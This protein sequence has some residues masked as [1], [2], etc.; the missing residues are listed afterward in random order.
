MTSYI[1]ELYIL[2]FIPFSF[3]LPC[4][5]VNDISANIE[6]NEEIDPDFDS[7]L[8]YTYALSKTKNK[9]G[10]VFS[11]V[12]ST[13]TE[14]IIYKSELDSNVN[15]YFDKFLISENSFKEIDVQNLEENIYI[16]IKDTKSSKTYNVNF[17]IYDTEIP[18]SLIEGKPK[19]MKYFFSTNIYKFEYASSANLTFVYSSKVKLKKYLNIT[20]NDKVI[21]EK[22]I[23]ETDK[24]FYLKSD[25]LET[26][27][28]KVEI[29]D[30]EPGN[31]D[32]EFSIIVYEKGKTQFIEIGKNQ[33]IDLYHLNLNQNDEVQTFL[34]YYIL[35]STVS[36][37]IN[38]KIDSIAKTTKYINIESGLYHSTRKINSDE[39]EKIFHFGENPLP[40]EYDINSDEYKKIYFKDVDTSYYYRY[41]FF[42]IDISKLEEYYSP[43]KI[44]ITIGEEVEEIN[45]DSMNYYQT[46]TI[47]KTIKPYFPTYFKLK[48]DPKE[49]Y[50]FNSPYPKNSIYVKGDLMAYDEN[51]KII[52]NKNY[53][54]DEDEIF[55]FSDI[56]E[57]TI[58]VFCSESFRGTFYLEK[59]K[60]SDL[61][62]LENMRN[63]D[64]IEIKFEENDC[65]TK[66]KKYLLGIYNREIYSKMNKTLTK[67]WTTNNGEMNVYYR[68]N[69]TLEGQSL[70]PYLDKYTMK[71]EYYIY[72][73][74]Y[75]DFFTF[76]CVKP[77]EL[78][79]RSPYK[80]FNET[81]HSIGQNTINIIKLGTEIEILQPTTPIRPPSNYLF[82]GIFSTFGK[83]IIISPD[84]PELFNETSIEN[85]KIFTLK[86]DLYKFEPDQLAI[87]VNAN[88]LTQIEV[89]EVIRYNFT[90]Y[91]LL[92]TSEMTHFTDNH[93]VKFINKKTKKIKVTVKGLKDVEISYDL[94][95]LFTNN[96]DYLPMAY[97][98]KETVTR[99]KSA[100]NEIIELNNKYLGD[101][102]LNKKYIAFIFS[103]PSS[104]YYEFDAQVIEDIEQKNE[105]DGKKG[106][107]SILIICIIAGVIIVALV[108]FL[109][110]FCIKKK[111]E[112]DKKYEMDVENM[113]NQPL[114]N[115]NN[116][117]INDN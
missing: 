68:N 94:V 72:I 52:I 35:N 28:L 55:V 107:K 91:T 116:L 9:I 66:R 6:Y 57:F 53:F 105:E 36:N 29:E 97:Q 106:N 87:K 39:F 80:T 16:L 47:S 103:I 42:K 108:V 38:F 79:L 37:T 113:G 96:L 27:Y 109:V 114:N 54:V 115:D 33:Q 30:I 69:I 48:L 5:E 49:R 93:F 15:N 86:I 58:A 88:E 44:I 67:Y 59:Y 83:K 61:Y 89:V 77:G 4:I 19:T 13:S 70:F 78:T 73:F 110:I 3:S 32:Q 90:E 92:K 43:K 41:I 101:D 1:K 75:I 14:V 8:C 74:N 25:D 98:F 112:K 17:I 11:K 10:F 117:G 40:I 21:I 99:K 56:S 102:D 95:K 46:K 76:V 82:L 12:N 7:Q 100:E 85:D 2:L 51:N 50:I 45:C 31:E 63:N 60:E 81:T 111:K 64:P 71:K 23:D 34:Y 26:K 104:K 65:K 20:Y 62:I 24:I 22:Q 84:C 18:I